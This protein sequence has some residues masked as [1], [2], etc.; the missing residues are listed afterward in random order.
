MTVDRGAGALAERLHGALLD[1]SHFDTARQHEFAAAILADGSVYLAAG[2]SLRSEP[3]LDEER[4]ARALL[5]IVPGY[6][7]W[8]TYPLT[9]SSAEMEGRIEAMQ[10]EAYGHAARIAAEY[11]VLAATEEPK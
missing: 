7:R 4:L 2:V 9:P 5:R 10:S 8:L 3:T 1:V 11:A 6:Q